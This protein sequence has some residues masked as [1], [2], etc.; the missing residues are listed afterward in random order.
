MI[1]IFLYPFSDSIDCGITA[2]E[3][4][5]GP[6]C[7]NLGTARLFLVVLSLI[8][9]FQGAIEIYFLTTV[10]Q[11]ALDY[12]ID[13]VLVGNYKTTKF[14]LDSLLNFHSF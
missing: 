10:R 2:I 7:R 6:G 9:I 4:C 5:N 13:R 8:G 12:N 3:C 1:H 11:A 14:L